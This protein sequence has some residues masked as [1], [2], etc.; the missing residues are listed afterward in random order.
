MSSTEIPR[1]SKTDATSARD[2]ERK[3]EAAPHI[4]P[5]GSQQSSQDSGASGGGGGSLRS[6]ISDTEGPRPLSTPTTNS[7]RAESSRDEERDN[8]KRTASGMY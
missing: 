3:R 1:G 7:Y 6:R 2:R 8:K 4:T 5:N